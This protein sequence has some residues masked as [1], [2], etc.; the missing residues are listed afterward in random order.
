MAQKNNQ[1]RTIS[2]GK[3]TAED[4][5]GHAIRFTRGKMQTVR[6]LVVRDIKDF[7]VLVYT[8]RTAPESN[9][10]RPGQGY[11]YPVNGIPWR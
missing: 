3:K 4:C 1:R 8:R 11:E 6:V 10:G 9:T 5:D 2:Q 7:A